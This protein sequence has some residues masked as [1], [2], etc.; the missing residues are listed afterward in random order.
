MPITVA[1][2]RIEDELVQ[3]LMH[4]RIIVLGEALE[5]GNGNRLMHQLLLL[6][7]E[8]PH[9]DISLWI[10]SPGGSVSAMLAIH[11]VMRL[12][13]NDV[14]T[15]AMGMAASAGQFLLSAGSPGKRYALPHSRVLLH[16]G[17]A[18]IGGTAVDIEIQAADLRL[19]RDTVIGLVAEHTGQDRETVERDSRRDRWFTATQALEYGFVD[20]VITTLDDVAPP[21]RRGVGLA[22]AR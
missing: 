5:E 20:R 15:L 6:S 11:D 12:I 3:R 19:T 17:S 13:P 7:A 16:Q 21:Q 2:G 18:G 8:D 4:Q 14:S 1:H 9:A 22:A 10:N